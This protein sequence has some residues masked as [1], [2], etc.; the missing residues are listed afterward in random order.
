MLKILGRNTS[1]NVQKVLWVGD[2]LKIQYER[3]DVG[4][5][6]GQNREPWYLALN[7]NGVVPTTD[8]DGYILWESNSIIR[9]LAEKH[10]QGSAI[11][12]K[13]IKARHSAYRWMDWQLT[14]L[15]PAHGPV[16]VGLIRTPPEKRDMNSINA[17]REKYSAA[18]KMMDDQ[19]AKT[20][21]LAGPDFT[22]GDIACGPLVFRWF[23]L[24][25]KREDYKNVK[26]YYD[27]LC[28]RPPFK[29]HIVDLGLS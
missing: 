26:R 10:G 14:V 19:L 24:D 16:F 6:F 11:H 17:G 29:K 12:P 7:P 9:Y 3:Q 22:V 15:G 23:A 27:A 13:D 2:E 8:D 21:Y 20:T 1:S 4:G 25:I 18:I 28:A 5:K